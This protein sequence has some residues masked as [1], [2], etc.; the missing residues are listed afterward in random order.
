[1]RAEGWI[2]FTENDSWTSANPTS[3]SCQALL[4]R[5]VKRGDVVAYSGTV[6]NVRDRWIARNSQQISSTQNRSD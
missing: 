5:E 6:G 3:S 4:G 1:M 2:Y